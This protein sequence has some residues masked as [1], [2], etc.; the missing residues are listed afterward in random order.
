V[1]ICGNDAFGDPAQGSTKH[2]GALVARNGV[3]FYFACEENQTIDF[4]HDGGPA[5]APSPLQVKFA[6]YG[7]LPNGDRSEARAFDVTSVVQATL[8]RSGGPVACNNNTF[9]DPSPGSQKHFAAVVTRGGK[10]FH[11]A[12]IEG[13]TIDFAQGGG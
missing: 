4:N 8:N 1:V 6:V 3:S 9:G 10:D 11:F 7:A 13:Q 12:C 2:F 5:Q